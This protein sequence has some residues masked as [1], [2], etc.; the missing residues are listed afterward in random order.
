MFQGFVFVVKGCKKI[1]LK[2]QEH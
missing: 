2:N 1:S